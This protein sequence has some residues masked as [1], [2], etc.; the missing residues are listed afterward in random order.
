MVD[1]G[2]IKVVAQVAGIGGIALG[3]LLLVFRDIIR[4]DI[5]SILPRR[6][7]Y[8]LLRLI[9]ILV[10]TVA[11]V[12]IGAWVYTSTTQVKGNE[13]GFVSPTPTPATPRPNT[14]VFAPEDEI[15]YREFDS[16][17]KKVK[18]SIKG[19]VINNRGDADDLITIKS[20][21]KLPNLQEEDVSHSYGGDFEIADQTG[22]K[23]PRPFV[24]P[25]GANSVLDCS[26]SFNYSERSADAFEKESM[27]R[28]TIT[29]E[30][31]TNPAPLLN[32]CFEDIYTPKTANYFAQECPKDF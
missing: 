6:E 18:F 24:L 9:I 8:K 3:V 5:F 1:T 29:F 31:E 16:K 32:F 12:G 21:L 26:V 13:Q 19:I 27:R 4:R 25:K 20:L 30:G 11:L 15:I 17:N 14:K 7:S 22:K 10:W 28:L 23:L 2:I